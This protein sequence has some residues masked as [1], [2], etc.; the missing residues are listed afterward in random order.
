MVGVTDSPAM[1]VT[2]TI[3]ELLGAQDNIE[4]LSKLQSPTIKSRNTPDSP[5]MHNP[6]V[7]KL[8][9]RANYGFRKN[10]GVIEAALKPFQDSR[11]DILK[12]LTNNGKVNIDLPQA[13]GSKTAERVEFDTFLKD[14]LKIEVEV[15]FFAI[16]ESELALDLNNIPI[17]ML[18]SLGKMIEDDMA[19]PAAAPVAKK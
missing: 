18:N 2:L 12:R 1:K 13:D 17:T 19:A 5:L 7:V 10:I 9:A 6:N 4:A 3:N 14:N 11:T 8:G 15:D 16:K